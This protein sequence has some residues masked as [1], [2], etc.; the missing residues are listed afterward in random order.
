[1]DERV[2]SDGAR[3]SESPRLDA[4]RKRSIVGIADATILRRRRRGRCGTSLGLSWSMAMGIRTRTAALA[5]LAAAGVAIAIAAPW[6]GPRAAEAARS[7][8]DRLLADSLTADSAA[9]ASL[10]PRL[11]PWLGIGEFV[12]TERLAE[13]SL[14]ECSELEQGAPSERRLRLR[15]RLADSSTVLLYAVADRELGSLERVEL[16]RRISGLGQRGF[17]WSS[18][19]DR[20]ESVWWSDPTLGR[21]RRVERGEV[22]RSGP[23]PRTLRALGRQLHTLPCP[24]NAAVLAP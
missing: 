15:L 11:R 3:D 21:S 2:D 8:F 6:H 16:I 7:P 12:R 17:I 4:D 10:P 13:L 1:V 9:F 22:P 18:T 5:A 24:I 19:R 23:I 20:T 14:A